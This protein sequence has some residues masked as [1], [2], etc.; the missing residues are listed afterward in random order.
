MRRDRSTLAGLLVGLTLAAPASSQMPTDQEARI[1][2]DAAVLRERGRQELHPGDPLGLVGNEQGS[3]S[4]R[5]RT[6]GLE[7]STNQAAPVDVNANY[8]RRIAMYEKGTTYHAALPA[9]SRP[10]S[11]RRGQ[12]I[13]MRNGA[14]LAS[15]S[16]T[17][18]HPPN[19]ERSFNS[20]WYVIA[21]LAL[22]IVIGRIA[23]NRG[24]PVNASA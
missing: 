4:F 9:A 7:Q 17:P 22:A 13:P 15:G 2:R 14:D 20:V 11:I 6:P 12:G 18:A 21:L 23:R 8:A 16:G 10:N 19:T 1:E 5:D 24:N 3:N